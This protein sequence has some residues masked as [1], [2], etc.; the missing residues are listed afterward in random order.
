MVNFT[1]NMNMIKKHT[2]KHFETNKPQSVIFHIDLGTEAGTT[3]WIL[4]GPTSVSYN[5][6]ITR[7][8]DIIEFVPYYL[9]AWHA[10]VV[11]SPTA[12]AKA[13]YG[14]NN[15]NLRSIGVCYEGK[16]VGTK[17]TSKQINAGKELIKFLNEKNKIKKYFIHQEL[18][19]YKPKIVKLFKRVVIPKKPV[20]SVCRILKLLTA[21]YGCN[22]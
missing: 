1:N 20:N 16:T 2:F 6:Y 9:G 14:K 7:K 18:T 4:N 17:A 12:E 21:K 10:G 8:G 19:S 22:N 15:P 13:F 3:D 11:S 5:Y